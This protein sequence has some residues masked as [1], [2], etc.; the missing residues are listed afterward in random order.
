MYHVDL[1]SGIGGFALAARWVGWETVGFCEI[2]EWCRRVLA[3]NFPG[4]PQH[5]D[6][7]TLTAEH[8]REWVGGESY[9]L[10]AGYP[11]QPFSHAGRRAGEADPRHLWP[12]IRSL[13]ASLS[14]EKPRWVCLE[15]VA[16]HVSLGLDRVLDELEDEGYACWAAIVPAAG[17]GA[18]HRRDRVW[19]VGCR[20]HVAYSSSSGVGWLRQSDGYAWVGPAGSGAGRTR[21]SADGI[22]AGDGAAPGESRA[23][24]EPGFRRAT[25]G[26]PAGMDSPLDLFGCGWEY[27][28]P[29]TVSGPT[30][31]RVHRLKALGNA[32]VP[33]VAYVVF[34]AIA[35]AEGQA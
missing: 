18:L 23:E 28:V 19:I 22:V 24:V 32:I 27:G 4:V 30:P 2:D 16:G 35:D 7:K 29:L 31:D 33:Q 13:I 25:D 20:E 34:C 26:L 12:W 15:N 10:T 1:T 5:D 21:A 17:V 11:C 6:L 8:V 14:A 9:V 3:K